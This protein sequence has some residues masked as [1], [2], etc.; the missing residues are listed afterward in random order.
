MEYPP[1]SQTLLIQGD[2]LSPCRT[3]GR[4]D[5]RTDVLEMEVLEMLAQCASKNKAFCA[6][7]PFPH[8]TNASG[9]H[10]IS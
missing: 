4:T 7:T 10:P 3:D 9:H 1:V 2:N 5:G 6:R 8:L